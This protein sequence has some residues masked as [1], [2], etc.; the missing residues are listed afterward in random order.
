MRSCFNINLWDRAHVFSKPC[1]IKLPTV[2]N[3]GIWKIGNFG[4][5]GKFYRQ[6]NIK[7]EKESV[8]KLISLTCHRSFPN[9]TC[10]TPLSVDTGCQTCRHCLQNNSSNQL[11]CWFDRDP[12]ISAYPICSRSWLASRDSRRM[13][14]CK[15]DPISRFVLTT[16]TSHPVPIFW[17]VSN[18]YHSN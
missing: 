11:S 16:K 3:W 6:Q 9:S 12:E 8:V 7:R 2:I 17:T 18:T 4:T 1:S 15:S 10:L 13:L 14:Y 5:R